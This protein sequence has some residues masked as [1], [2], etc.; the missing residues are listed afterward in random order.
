ML[1][2]Q[3][4]AYLYLATLIPAASAVAGFSPIALRLRPFLVLLKKNA[5]ARAIIIAT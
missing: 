5:L 3:V 4:D 2:M 1:P